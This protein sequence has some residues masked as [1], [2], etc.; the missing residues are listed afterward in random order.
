MMRARFLACAVV[1]LMGLACWSSPP[2]RA[3]VEDVQSPIFV[4]LLQGPHTEAQFYASPDLALHASYSRAR[5]MRTVDSHMNQYGTG[6]GFDEVRP[7]FQ[8]P[9]YVALSR[10]EG[11][12]RSPK[13]Q[14]W[15]IELLAW[16][17]FGLLFLALLD[18]TNGP[19]E[20]ARLMGEYGANVNSAQSGPRASNA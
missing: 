9:S 8:S 16:L 3:L 7:T 11:D 5:H 19:D 15:L 4:R 1:S 17:P 10:N 12:D 13:D 2:T 14:E 20:V 6:L 18:R